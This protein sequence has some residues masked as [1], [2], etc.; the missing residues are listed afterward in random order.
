MHFTRS[1]PDGP[2]SSRQ[3]HPPEVL[4]RS[5]EA[6]QIFGRQMTEYLVVLQVSVETKIKKDIS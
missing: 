5:S 2:R 1:H 6:E 3:H 4:A